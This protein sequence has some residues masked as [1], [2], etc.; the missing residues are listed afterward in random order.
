MNST[1]CHIDCFRPFSQWLHDNLHD[2]F[3][4][5][6][7]LILL[8]LLPSLFQ[9]TILVLAVFPSGG[10]VVRL[11]HLPGVNIHRQGEK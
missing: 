5:L 9:A 2:S 7:H 10:D 8:T 1:T 3:L 6:E 11:A 4:S